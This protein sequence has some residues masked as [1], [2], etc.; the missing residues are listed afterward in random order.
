MKQIIQLSLLWM[1][2]S[3]LNARGQEAMTLR[4]CMEYAVEKSTQVE[5]QKADNSDARIQ[6][7][8]AILSTFVPSVTAG[9][10]A[11]SN[12]GRTVDP[13]TNTY[14]STTSFANGY[15]VNASLTLF[16]GFTAL[17]N[18]RI[19]KTAVKMGISREQQLRDELCLA[20]MESF[21]NVLFHAR[22]ITAL[23]SQVASVRTNLR[24]VEK[25]Y[26]QGQKSY[27]DVAQI[28]ADLADRE[29]QL[30][31]TR[32]QHDDALFTLKSVMLWPVEEELR[33]DDSIV[34]ESFR[35]SEIP[36]PEQ[37]QSASDVVDYAQ[38]NLPAVQIARGKLRNARLELQTAKLQ[39]LPT[40]SLNGGWSTSYYTYPGRAS[41]HPTPFGQ[42]WRN[43][44]G[45][46]VQVSMTIP[47]FTHLS[48]FSNLSRKKNGY[49]RAEAEYRQTM[50]DVE[51]EVHRA[52]HECEGSYMAMVQAQKRSVVQ[53]EAFRLNERKYQQGILSPIDYQTVSDAYL[54]AQAE[55]LN[56]MLQYRLKSSVV[57]YYQG[58]SYLEQ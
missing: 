21:Y 23:E 4:S 49:K 29:Y 58:I 55:E 2:L 3:S 54:K 28:E 40:L 44:G 10:H 46:Y 50:H 53:Q 34:D 39:F 32:N 25:Q 37:H 14:I 43:N 12:F 11:Y 5:I 1:L 31:Q 20:V 33:L 56:S 22:M 16:N 41:Y 18:I 42:Q 19:S 36:L 35:T 51:T 13:E 8:D 38:V 24:L 17:N 57:K 30:L 48:L 7:R 52:I 9:T 6:R 27:P 45:E 26:E 15:S 47:I